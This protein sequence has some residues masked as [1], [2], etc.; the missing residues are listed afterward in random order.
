MVSV[1]ARSLERRTLICLACFLF[2]V[3][4]SAY[5]RDCARGAEYWCRDAATAKDCGATQHC[6]DTV[7]REQQQKP[8]TKID[9]TAQML[10]NVLVQASKELLAQ[11]PMAVNSLKDSLR[12]DC[13]KLPK[14]MNLIKRVTSLH[15]FSQ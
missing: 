11:T 14:Q 1:S 8:S 10:C 7:W 3:H 9:E 4:V 5:S 12:R 6:Q 15:R 2:T 13:A